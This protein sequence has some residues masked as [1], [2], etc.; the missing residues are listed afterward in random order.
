MTVADRLDALG[1]RLR[2]AVFASLLVNC[3][4]WWEVAGLTQKPPRFHMDII[5]VSR[6]TID[7]Q[8]RKIEKVV[9]KE[10]IKRK[11]AEVHKEIECLT[12]ILIAQQPQLPPMQSRVL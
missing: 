4:L 10:Q 12:S 8:G 9:K 11:L 6:V 7:K 2:W 1:P 3:L 5:Q